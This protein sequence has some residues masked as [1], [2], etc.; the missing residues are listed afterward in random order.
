MSTA[1]MAR[2]D[3]TCVADPL[4]RKGVGLQQTGICPP[5]TQ[6]NHTLNYIELYGFK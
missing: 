3:V 6:I 2:P 1:I 4:T 5:V